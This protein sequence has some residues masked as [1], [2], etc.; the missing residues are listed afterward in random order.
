MRSAG[1]VVSNKMFRAFNCRLLS[2]ATPGRQ[3]VGSRPPPA[4]A[5]LWS[6]DRL[7]SEVLKPS[8]S[9]S[10]R[11]AEH[12][13]SLARELVKLGPR[14][15]QAVSPVLETDAE[16]LEAISTAKGITPTNQGRKRQEGYIGKLLM[17]LSSEQQEEID[18]QLNG[19][20][21]KSNRT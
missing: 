20:R 5:A 14:Q 2:T 15:L 4:I 8:K 10:K 18:R 1:G 3:R 9:S 19:M 6:D 12:L 16:L 13:R 21:K 11:K 7:T 17:S